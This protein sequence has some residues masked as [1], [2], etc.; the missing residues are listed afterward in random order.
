LGNNIIGTNSNQLV[1]TESGNYRVKVE[2]SALCSATS[3]AVALT[4][5][6]LPSI[7]S[8]NYGETNVCSG[9]SV[10]FSVNSNSNPYFQWYRNNEAI[11]NA[12][13]NNYSA[14]Q[15]GSYKIQLTNT[16]NIC[17]IFS[18]TVQVTI[19]ELPS[20]PT[21]S[22]ATNNTHFCFG[23]KV[24]LLVTNEVPELNYQWKRSGI[25]INGATSPIYA[26]KLIAGD[27]NIEA[28]AGGCANE[29]DILTLTTKPAPAKPT[30]N[31]RGPNVWILGCSNIAATD[32]RWFYNNQLI[33]GAKA[34]QY[35]A[36]RNYGDY[37]VEINEGSE[38]YSASNIVNIAAPSLNF[39]ASYITNSEVAAYPNP[40]INSTYISFDKLQLEKIEV[41][42]LDALGK[43]FAKFEIENTNGFTVELADK[44]SGV[45]YCRIKYLDSVVV[46][47]IVKL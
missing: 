2:N 42:I 36:N 6:P 37:Y 25:S 28:R 26:G 31:A 45:Y 14:T 4:R 8:F 35:V 3:P 46:K 47:K 32:Y 23:T 43:V 16:N 18:Q 44:P 15:S 11:E 9:T 34:H 20:K 10:N 40:T 29:S 41:E 13:S 24:E 17:N 27:Y 19:N 5:N 7:S 33:V 21:I 38:C 39:A 12:T 22:E 30:L 1:A